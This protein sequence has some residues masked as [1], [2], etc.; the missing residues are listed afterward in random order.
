LAELRFGLRSTIEALNQ[1]VELR[2]A[3][4]GQASA[5]RDDYIATI[6]VAA[7]M[8]LMPLGNL[9]PSLDPRQRSA[10]PPPSVPRPLLIERPIYSVLEFLEANDRPIASAARDLNQALEPRQ[11]MGPLP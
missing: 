5:R 11:Q 10:I 7:L 8:G 4:I 1:E 3:L 6:E 9:P 2:Q